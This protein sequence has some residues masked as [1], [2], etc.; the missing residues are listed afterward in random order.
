MNPLIVGISILAV[1]MIISVFEK[2]GRNSGNNTVPEIQGATD[3]ASAAPLNDEHLEQLQEDGDIAQD[4]G[5][6]QFY[7]E[8]PNDLLPSAMDSND[9]MF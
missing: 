7:P 5:N 1:V 6:D 3:D 2:R 8:G 9:P 4:D